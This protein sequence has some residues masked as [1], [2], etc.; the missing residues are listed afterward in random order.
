[1]RLHPETGQVIRRLLAAM[2][3]ALSGTAVLA[4]LCFPFWAG[5]G[6]LAWY[7]LPY[8]ALNVTDSGVLAGSKLV[9]LALSY[10]ILAGTSYALAY[11]LR[12]LV[13][14]RGSGIRWAAGAGYSISIVMVIWGS[15]QAGGYGEMMDVWPGPVWLASSA[16]L[17]LKW[18][19]ADIPLMLARRRRSHSICRKCGY[20]LRE[21]STSMCPECGEAK[22]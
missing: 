21:S 1:M 3:V 20:D 7:D 5:H 16:A 14:G 9:R 12:G 10:L 19:T 2:E 17:L 15:F 22:E 13:R 4:A 6:W 11:S 18:T 8:Y